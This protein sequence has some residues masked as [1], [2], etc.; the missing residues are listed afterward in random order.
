MTGF[1]WLLTSSHF[2]PLCQEFGEK[3]GTGAALFEAACR[4]VLSSASPIVLRLVEE[5][6]HQTLS[7]DAHECYAGRNGRALPAFLTAL[8]YSLIV[9]FSL[10]ALEEARATEK[11]TACFRISSAAR[12]GL[13]SVPSHSRFF[14]QS[15]QSSAISRDPLTEQHVANV[16]SNISKDLTVR[17][18]AYVSILPRAS[19]DTVQLSRSGIGHPAS[20]SRAKDTIVFTCGHDIPYDSMMDVV[21]PDFSR[22]IQSLPADLNGW[23][24]LVA[25][26]YA[27][28]GRFREKKGGWGWWERGA[29]GNA[30]NRRLWTSNRTSYHTGASTYGL[31]SLCI[32]PH[33]A[34]RH[35][36]FTGGCEHTS[37]AVLALNYI[38]ICLAVVF[39]H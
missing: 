8:P 34:C 36:C 19:S 15:N 25:Q 26:L 28:V 23:L 24:D 1:G 37:M 32:W 6:W 3:V 20:Q 14:P 17:D 11:Q 38:L 29:P 10:T 35:G 4:L 16:L 27:Q 18:H 2:P 21:L 12:L 31:P 33:A 13:I 5:A 39:F 7:D 9:D 30:A 22:R